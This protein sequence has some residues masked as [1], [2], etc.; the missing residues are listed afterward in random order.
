MD[1][2][3][4]ILCFL[5]FCFLKPFSTYPLVAQ[6]VID[7]NSQGTQS[8]LNPHLPMWDRYLDLLVHCITCATHALVDNRY[9]VI[10]VTDGDLITQSLVATPIV[11]QVFCAVIEDLIESLVATPIA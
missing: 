9:Q 4:T 3:Y 11:E 5:L 10:G 1:I 8:K 7:F 6:I 2:D